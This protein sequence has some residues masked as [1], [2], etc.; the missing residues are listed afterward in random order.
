MCLKV[1]INTS[2]DEI[3]EMDKKGLLKRNLD[4]PVLIDTFVLP[5]PGYAILRFK[6]DNPGYWLFH[7]HILLHSENGMTMVFKVGNES[8][9]PKRPKSWKM[10]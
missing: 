2:P 3:I 6:A 5:N 8:Q 7:C 4:N 9:F 1:P 10:C